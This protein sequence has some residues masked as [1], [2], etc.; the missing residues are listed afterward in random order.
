MV[1]GERARQP[2]SV[3]MMDQGPNLRTQDN[4]RT[5]KKNTLPKGSA[6]ISE[7]MESNRNHSGS[8]SRKNPS[9]AK[10]CRGE[11]G[12]SAIKSDTPNHSVEPDKY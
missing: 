8:G 12:W 1:W 9:S 6:S 5:R 4:L 2:E 7:G 11:N 10:Q 3:H